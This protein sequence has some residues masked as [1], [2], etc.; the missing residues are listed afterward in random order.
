MDRELF[1]DKW[2]ENS[3]LLVMK[4]VKFLQVSSKCLVDTCKL[5]V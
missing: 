1:E 4:T 3:I 5:C 2:T